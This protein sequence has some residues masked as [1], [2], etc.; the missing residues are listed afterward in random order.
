MYITSIHLPDCWYV[1]IRHRPED[2]RGCVPDGNQLLQA[3]MSCAALPPLPTPLLLPLLL[4]L[5][6][7]R[8][9]AQC[10]PGSGDRA[11]YAAAS[12]GGTT[13][14]GLG[15]VACER[16]HGGVAHVDCDPPGFAFSGCER[17]RCAIPG[18]VPP[19]ERCTDATGLCPQG[20]VAAYGCGDIDASNAISAMPN[21]R[22]NIGERLCPLTCG[23][24]PTPDATD[25]LGYFPLQSDDFPLRKRW[26]TYILFFFRYNIQH[27]IDD[28]DGVLAGECTEK[29]MIFH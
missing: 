11:G 13:V 29:M 3:G 9:A 27:C 6:C 23:T 14:A 8:A 2:S 16:T 26:F 7:P 21:F 24:C 28:W 5:L 20:I 15:A 25:A 1:I 22:G 4:L 10:V 12:P 19:L 17:L 18:Y